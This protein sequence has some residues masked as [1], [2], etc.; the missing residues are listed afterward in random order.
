MPAYD[1]FQ[2]SYHDRLAALPPGHVQRLTDFVMSAIFATPGKCDHQLV[3]IVLEQYLAQG[4]A[5]LPSNA[6]ATRFDSCRSTIC[7]ARRR[8]VKAGFIREI[9]M[10]D[11]RQYMYAPCLE[12][13]DEYRASIDLEGARHAA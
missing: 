4:F 9:G 1:H 3:P 2:L 11:Q 5:I 6:L 8:L 7:A 13:A 10:N 12:R